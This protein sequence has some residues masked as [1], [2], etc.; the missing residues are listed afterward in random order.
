MIKMKNPSE[1]TPTELCEHIA[2]KC[3]VYSVNQQYN[4]PFLAHYLFWDS[5]LEIV[6]KTFVDTKEEE[7]NTDQIMS[8]I[9]NLKILSPKVDYWN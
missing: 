5:I 3:V 7:L 6:A 9:R 1:M 4:I 2:Y 8:I